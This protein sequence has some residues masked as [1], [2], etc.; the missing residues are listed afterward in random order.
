[1]FD[2]LNYYE[3]W[4]LVCAGPVVLMVL[5]AVVNEL[6]ALIRK[7]MGRRRVRKLHF[8]NSLVGIIA[9][10]AIYIIGVYILSFF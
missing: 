7:K 5:L 4:I 2:K 1:M 3:I 6:G 9:L 10:I 8:K